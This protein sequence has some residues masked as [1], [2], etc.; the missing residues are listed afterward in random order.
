MRRHKLSDE[1]HDP[2][3]LSRQQALDDANFYIDW[4]GAYGLYEL[5]VSTAEFG[6]NH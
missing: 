4:S 6:S 2:R 5:G 3:P 1:E